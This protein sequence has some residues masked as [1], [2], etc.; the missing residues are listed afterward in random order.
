MMAKETQRMGSP[1]SVAI[2]GTMNLEMAE[3]NQ[4]HQLSMGTSWLVVQP[5]TLP[6]SFQ[7]FEITF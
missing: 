3:S 5:G 6:L 1:L 7:T 4:L 2:A